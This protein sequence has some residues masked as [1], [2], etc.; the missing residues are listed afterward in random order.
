MA[1]SI[2][3][4][5][6]LFRRFL[7]F[8]VSPF[9]ISNISA[10]STDHYWQQEVNYTIHVS[11]DDANNILDGD[12]SVEYTNRSPDTLRFIWFHLWPNAFKNTETAFAN[13]RWRTG[14]L[15]FNSHLL[16]KRGISTAWIL[17]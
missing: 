10:Q 15:N 16:K 13:S 2:G 3:T 6:I 14:A 1:L 5:M 12:L 11:L 4:Q 17:R 7:L 9:S 8:F